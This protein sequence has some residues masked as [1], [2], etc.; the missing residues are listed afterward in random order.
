M[1]FRH[2]LAAGALIA[3]GLPGSALAL[4][5]DNA[6]SSPPPV[7]RLSLSPA[8]LEPGAR[9]LAA[10]DG[11]TGILVG[12]ELRISVAP[13][14]PDVDQVL[15]PSVIGGYQLYNTFRVGSTSGHNSIAP[16]ETGTLLYA[17]DANSN[18]IPDP[19]DFP[20]VVV[21]V[22]L[23][24]DPQNEPYQQEVRGIVSAKNRPILAPKITAVGKSAV[25][26]LNT[27]KI[28]FG[29]DTPQWYTAPSFDG[30]GFF[31]TVTDPNALPTPTF[32][33]NLPGFV[34]LAPRPD[35]LVY[36]AR[37]TNDV[38]RAGEDWL[39]PSTFVGQTL[40]FRRGGD[41]TAWIDGD[42]P[43][44]L[45]ATLTQGDL[46][47]EWTLRPSLAS[48]SSQRSVSY[49]EDDL[50]KWERSWIAYQCGKGPKPSLPLAP[51]SNTPVAVPGGPNCPAVVNPPLVNSVTNNT[52]VMPPAQVARAQAAKRSAT[53]KFIRSGGK[54][55][56]S[57]T[58]TSPNA[59]ERV[60][61]R[62][63]NRKNFR[64]RAVAKTLPTNRA[65]VANLKVPS[66]AVKVK[67]V[68]SATS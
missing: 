38:D 41:Q 39:F 44:P 62:L 34:G 2:A 15:V 24:A 65:V 4:P 18:G 30:A 19:V 9:A 58:I 26:T 5:G 8:D 27:Y 6:V 49:S 51:G 22:S 66:S 7:F 29:Y 42:T 35:D 16:G 56:V 17:P 45:L 60:T 28:G 61:V 1:K 46:P 53:A 50:A 57:V 36:D 47:L 68:L 48:A 21:A 25:T 40:F 43:L 12:N 3:L 55:R 37:R 52:T 14:S 23:S 20:D 11:I 63:Y 59:Q 64:L 33:G 67:A 54:R 13:G 10:P 31:P 32:T